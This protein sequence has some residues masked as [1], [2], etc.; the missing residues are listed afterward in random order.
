[1]NERG[2]TLVELLVAAGITVA[3]TGALLQFATMTQRLVQAHGDLSDLNQRARVAGAVLYRDLVMAGAGPW[4]GT[5]RGSLASILP[6]L[7]P[8]RAGAKQPD[9]ELAFFTD[10]ISV[11]YVPDSR[12]QTTLAA[13]MAAAGAPL[14]IDTAAPGCPAGGAC[15]FRAGG[16]AV[17]LGAQ[18]GRFDAFTVGTAG[19]GLLTSAAPLSAAYAQGSAVAAVTERV[20]Y[21]DR[22][23]RRLMVY[24]GAQTDAVLLDNVSD[25][26]F[27]WF[28]TAAGSAVAWELL[29]ETS[30]AD[31]PLLGAYPNRF[32]ADLMRVRRIRVTLTLDAPS[33]WTGW[34]GRER[35]RRLTFDV[36]PRN[37]MRP[38][39]AP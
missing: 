14:V 13:D 12:S 9:P 15:G 32:D 37:M 8:A 11:L 10:R 17:V 33:G 1:M 4:H 36:T 27:E 29:G 24:D 16:R 5:A 6:A 23:G 20:Y 25:L 35:T 31:G 7:R 19:G 26:R 28:G 18:P 22:L 2:V 38:G 21:L 34:D 3:V 39:T 30:L